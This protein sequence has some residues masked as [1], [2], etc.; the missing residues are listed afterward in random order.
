MPDRDD[1]TMAQSISSL[2]GA[3]AGGE[4]YLTAAYEL[5]DRYFD[6][7]DFNVD[8][9]V[10]RFKINEMRAPFSTIR[11]EFAR[12]G[13]YPFLR[14]RAKRR[15]CILVRSRRGIHGST[16][17]ENIVAGALFALTLATTIM[18]GFYFSHPLAELNFVKNH[19][20]GA[21]CFSLGLLFILGCHEMGHKITSI[22]RGIDASPPFFIPFP[23]LGVFGIDFITLGTLGAVIKVRSPI[24]DDNTAVDMGL[25]GPIA[26]FLAALPVTA[27]G[28]ILSGMSTA[29]PSIALE[30]GN[31]IIMR[32]MLFV[33]APA[34]Q[35]YV[36]W[37]PLVYA[38]WV[39]FFIT[40]L[41]LI[42][43]GQLD[44]GHVAR[45]IIGNRRFKKFSWSVVAVLAA[46]GFF[47]PVWWVWAALGAALTARGY[48]RV[49]NE[50]VPLDKKR[51]Q[52]AWLGAALFVICF[53]PV[54][55]LEY[56]QR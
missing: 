36:V 2:Y 43:I 51:K 27:I 30:F 52:K 4:K 11:K 35:G 32:I 28:L 17:R 56:L 29:P 20:F 12:I 50:F 41:N 19:W 49:M 44:G 18:A 24:P 47:H 10:I 25:N 3:A 42:P 21:V 6:A 7:Q 55:V 26:G 38:G 23:S 39:G 22:R 53:V 33:F 1:G 48:P 46:F 8:N 16:L 54:P 34:G 40:S 13:Y 15:V 9:R 37:H 14:T 45:A 31:S 5:I